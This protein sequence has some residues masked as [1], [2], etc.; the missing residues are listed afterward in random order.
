MRV[1]AANAAGVCAGAYLDG[2][3]GTTGYVR[4]SVA[5][6]GTATFFALAPGPSRPAALL[7]R[8]RPGAAT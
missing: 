8:W 6:A 3:D 2:V 5:V 7:T 4:R 1:P